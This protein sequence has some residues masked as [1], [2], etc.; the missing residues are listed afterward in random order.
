MFNG[1]CGQYVQEKPLKNA[2][3]LQE[4]SPSTPF[5]KQLYLRFP[6]F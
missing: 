2:K 3:S 6:L 4:V 5:A 1:K